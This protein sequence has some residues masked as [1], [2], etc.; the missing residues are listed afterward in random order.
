MLEDLDTAQNYLLKS[1]ELFPDNH[2]VCDGLAHIYD[3]HN[4]R[5]NMRF[6]GNKSLEIKDKEAF[7]AD[8]LN[9]LYKHTG[10]QY[11]INSD[12]P[13]FNA[14]TPNKNIISFSLW[15]DNPEYIEGAILNATLAPIIYP[16]WKCR[17]YCDTSVN[18]NVIEQLK[19]RG[20]EARILDKNTLLF[21]GL[22][23]HF[24]CD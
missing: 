19:S 15:R 11:V 21:F 12:A 23:W 4:D 14:N 1:Y 8:N 18:T 13:I 20:A 2:R 7:A 3:I 10:H 17:F 6:F 22:F 9:N 24:F 5:K 16:S